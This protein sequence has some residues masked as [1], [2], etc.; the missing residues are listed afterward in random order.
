MPRRTRFLPRGTPRAVGTH[1]LH[2]A[3]AAF[4]G[5]VL[6]KTMLFLTW[7][8]VP[9]IVEGVTDAQMRAGYVGAV[10]TN[11]HTAPLALDLGLT[12]S[13]D[14][15]FMYL[16]LLYRRPYGMAVALVMA[17]VSW[18]LYFWEVGFFR[19]MLNSEYPIWYELLNFVEAPIAFAVARFVWGITNASSDRGATASVGQGGSR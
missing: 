3:I 9:A 6:V 14:I 1:I 2:A 15:G 13:I 16:A 4:I 5:I 10:L 7:D 18:A 8:V 19:G 11:P 12:L 17:A